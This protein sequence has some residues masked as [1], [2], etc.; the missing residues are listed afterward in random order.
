MKMFIDKTVKWSHSPILTAKPYIGLTTTSSSGLKFTLKYLTIVGI[1]WGAHPIGSI[2][3]SKRTTNM[4]KNRRVL[5]R[6]IDALNKDPGEHRPSLNQIIQFQR[7]KVLAQT[8][9]PN[10]FP[11]WEE[12]NWL[13]KPYYYKCRINPI[14]RF[15][16]AF[17]HWMLLTILRNVMKKSEAK[18]GDMDYGKLVYE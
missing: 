18:F 4:R 7:K 3:A 6:F 12:N 17:Y 15:I 11:Y 5:A 8:V 1:N 9:F 14:K 2:W 10:D 13:E 16:G